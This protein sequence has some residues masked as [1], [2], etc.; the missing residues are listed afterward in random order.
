MGGH[1]HVHVPKLPDYR[2]YKVEDIPQ[3]VKNKENLAKLGLKDPWARNEVW[4]FAFLNRNTTWGIFCDTAGRGFKT[5][6]ALGALTALGG[7]LWDRHN[8]HG[9]G[10]GHGDDSG[11]GHGH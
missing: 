4:R 10:H 2:S 3:L 8:G 9:H 5:G 11:H 7:Y 6:W 1:H